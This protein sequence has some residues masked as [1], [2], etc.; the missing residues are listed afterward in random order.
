MLSPYGQTNATIF[1][2]FT[3]KHV[4]AIDIAFVCHFSAEKI[5][6]KHVHCFMYHFLCVYTTR[7]EAIVFRYDIY[8]FI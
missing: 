2:Y 6:L 5:L 4:E 7:C 1:R 3:L 8:T